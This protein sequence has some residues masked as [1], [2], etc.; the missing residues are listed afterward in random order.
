MTVLLLSIWISII[1]FSCLIAMARA[2]NTMV[3]KSGES[4]Y[5][6]LLLDLKGNALSFS[7][8]SMMLAVGF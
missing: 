7:P 4:V 5:P 3:N 1:S 6:F 8:L 2:L